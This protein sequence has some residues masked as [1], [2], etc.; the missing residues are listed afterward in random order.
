MNDL[1][2][3]QNSFDKPTYPTLV[4]VEDD[5]LLGITLKKYLERTFGLSVKLYTSS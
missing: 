1:N 5:N 4:I 3:L 2:F